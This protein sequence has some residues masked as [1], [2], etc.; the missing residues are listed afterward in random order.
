MSIKE[1]RAQTANAAEFYARPEIV[2]ELEE[3]AAEVRAFL[4]AN[5]KRTDPR[6]NLTGEGGPWMPQ[7]PPTDDEDRLDVRWSQF[8]QSLYGNG[9][10]R[11][12]NVMI[13][14]QILAEKAYE[15]IGRFTDFACMGLHEELVGA[16]LAKNGNT[17]NLESLKARFELAEGNNTTTLR[18]RTVVPMATA[19]LLKVYIDE[20][21][22]YAISIGQVAMTFHNHV[23]SPV[24]KV[25]R[26][27]F[28][29]LEAVK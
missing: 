19:G 21:N 7:L 25:F 17:I 24:R 9:M 15:D 1:A 13:D 3:V 8:R 18:D 28:L 20:G 10:R 16:A 14:R 11:M 27:Q 12:L 2:E 22:R 4:M 23:F 29:A 26:P 5:R 6:G